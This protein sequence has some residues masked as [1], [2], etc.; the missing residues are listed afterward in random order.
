VT[1]RA[2]RRW[3]TSFGILAL[4]AAAALST[5]ASAPARD[6]RVGSL[7]RRST[8]A[9]NSTPTLAVGRVLQVHGGALLERVVEQQQQQQ[10][11]VVG[12]A[13]WCEQVA[14]VGEDACRRA[15]RRGG[16]PGRSALRQADASAPWPS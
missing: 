9:D 12:G 7:S 10:Q 11:L 2:A 1:A 3:G 8:I 4:V 16:R 6:R 14:V 13:E 5:A 15:S